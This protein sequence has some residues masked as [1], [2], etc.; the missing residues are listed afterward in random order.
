MLVEER[1]LLLEAIRAAVLC[2]DSSLEQKDAA[3]LVH[4]DPMEGALLVS[5]AYR[6]LLYMRVSILSIYCY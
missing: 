2:N 4:G 6:M 5:G 3:W 1:P